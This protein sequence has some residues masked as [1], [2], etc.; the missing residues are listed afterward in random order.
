M[1]SRCIPA[2]LELSSSL[3]LMRNTP[4]AMFGDNFQDSGSYR[5]GSCSVP[6]DIPL[7]RPSLTSELHLQPPSLASSGGG[8]MKSELNSPPH[9]TDF[10]LELMY[11]LVHESMCI[12]FYALCMFACL[13]VYIFRNIIHTYLWIYV[14][15]HYCVKECVNTYWLTLT[16]DLNFSIFPNWE[17]QHVSVTGGAANFQAN[18]GAGGQLSLR[19]FLPSIYPT[20]TFTHS[21]CGFRYN[22]GNLLSSAT[23]D[24]TRCL[25]LRPVASQVKTRLQSTPPPCRHEIY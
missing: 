22:S 24:F 12:Y 2:C 17:S 3:A 9:T 18:T 8:R 19:L 10:Q 15:I 16:A 11:I 21:S 14:C 5:V 20:P 4:T 1:T 23:T 13:Y 7:F 6:C 25:F